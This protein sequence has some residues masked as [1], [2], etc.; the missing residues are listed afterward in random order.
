MSEKTYAVLRREYNERR[1]ALVEK[2]ESTSSRSLESEVKAAIVM[3]DVCWTLFRE[4]AEKLAFLRERQ[5]LNVQAILDELSN[6]PSTQPIPEEYKKMEK[7]LK[8]TTSSELIEEYL[9]ELEETL[10]YLQDANSG[11]E[12]RLAT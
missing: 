1:K 4:M 3:T 8:E 2:L 7:L 10:R 5:K 6:S 11:N 12:K 9:Q